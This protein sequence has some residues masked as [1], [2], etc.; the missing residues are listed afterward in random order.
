MFLENQQIRLEMYL[1]SLEAPYFPWQSEIPGTTTTVEIG[2][3]LWL[4]VADGQH[5]TF[6]TVLTWLEEMI[7]QQYLQA[8][9]SFIPALQ[10]SFPGTKQVLKICGI[11][12]ILIICKQASVHDSHKSILM[13]RLQWR[14]VYAA[15]NISEWSR[16][17]FLHQ[18]YSM[19][20]F[21]SQQV[22]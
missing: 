21:F 1:N 6:L 10:I 19:G 12:L 4:D 9:T 17:Q 5:T 14:K 16:E 8:T 22:Y 2:M 15:G 11:L 20:F 7:L 18:L 3:V 13:K